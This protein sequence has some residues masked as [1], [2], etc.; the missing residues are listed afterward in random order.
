MLSIL[1]FNYI[2]SSL[3]HYRTK[4]WTL[5]SQ[6][7]FATSYH[8]QHQLL[9]NVDHFNSRRWTRRFGVLLP[10]PSFIF[11]TFKPSNFLS[12]QQRRLQGVHILY[13]S[14]LSF[15]V[16]HCPALRTYCM[17]VCAWDKR[18]HLQCI[19]SPSLSASECM[20]GTIYRISI[21]IYNIR[22]TVGVGFQVP[23]QV[24]FGKKTKGDSFV[25][26][27]LYIWF[28]CIWYLLL[29]NT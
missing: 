28:S 3:A 21:L 2:P 25:S 12:F 20:W 10:S 7:T 16:L 5:N 8:L 29:S 14:S 19:G 15:D 23:M 24:S 11:V 13:V 9:T 22:I 6:L 4:P 17:P 18:L 26:V 27:S 1:Y